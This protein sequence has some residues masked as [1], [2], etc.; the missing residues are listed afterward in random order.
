MQ[1]YKFA[2]SIKAKEFTEK[3]IANASIVTDFNLVKQLYA[4]N[5]TMSVIWTE[6]DENYNKGLNDFWHKDIL[7]AEI[8]ERFTKTGEPYYRLSVTYN[9]SNN[10]FRL[11]GSKNNDYIPHILTKDEIAKGKFVFAKQDGQIVKE[12]AKNLENKLAR[13]FRVYF[14]PSEFVP[15][16]APAPAK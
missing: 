5:G 15:A 7:T 11:F 4:K 10:E 14:V 1:Y 16:P 12:D 9:D 2:K 6:S 8:V 3:E 13:S